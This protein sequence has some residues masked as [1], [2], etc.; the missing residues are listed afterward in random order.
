MF[1]TLVIKQRAMLA[2]PLWVQPPTFY[3]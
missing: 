1:N 3:S 2:A